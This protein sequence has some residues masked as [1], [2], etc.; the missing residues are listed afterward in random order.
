MLG[1][2]KTDKP[3][4]FNSIKDY[5]SEVAAGVA[6]G[7]AGFQFHQGLSLVLVFC[8]WRLENW[9]SIPSRIINF[10]FRS[11]NKYIS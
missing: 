2:I 9:L 4:A 6:G 11:C 5:R 3:I 1:I 7:V 8:I 10:K